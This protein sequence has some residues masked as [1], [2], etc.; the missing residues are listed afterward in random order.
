MAGNRMEPA[1]TNNSAAGGASANSSQPQAAAPQPAS[2]GLGAWLPLVVTIV[3][4]PILAIATTQFLLL[5]KLK[6]A[7]SPPSAPADTHAADSTGAEAGSEAKGGSHGGSTPQSSA[8]GS[9]SGG[10]AHGRASKTVVPLEKVLVNISGTL[11]SR[12]LMV[13]VNLAGNSPDLKK[14]VSDNTDQLR[15]LA[16]GVLATKTIVELDKPEARNLIRSELLSLFNNTL[17]SGMVQEIYITE[18]AI[19]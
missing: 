2:G 12:Y 10:G 4:M 7:S 6:S 17:G 8:H 11:G 1:A 14:A 13:K 19:Q 9:S 15:D 5:P 3:A 18:F 16:M